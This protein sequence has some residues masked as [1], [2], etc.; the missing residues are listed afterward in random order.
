MLIC[1]SKVV[2]IY[3]KSLRDKSYDKCP[4]KVCKVGF[5]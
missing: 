4:Y 1:S 5:Y 2:I 3:I